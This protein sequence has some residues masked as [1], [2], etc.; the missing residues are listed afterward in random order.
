M[1]HVDEREEHLFVR[2]VFIVHAHKGIDLS[3]IGRGLQALHACISC[4]AGHQCFAIGVGAQQVSHL[5]A[6][7]LR[8]VVAR[9]DFGYIS[10]I[11]RREIEIIHALHLAKGEC[12]RFGSG[13]RLGRLATEEQKGEQRAEERRAAKRENHFW[14]MKILIG[15]PEK[16]Q[17]SRILFSRK[18][19]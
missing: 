19:L 7:C 16:S 14:R 11:L 1:I 10:R 12:G 17:R 8:S 3:A 9:G 13:R 6:V 5:P 4:A 18:R 15:Q 2:V